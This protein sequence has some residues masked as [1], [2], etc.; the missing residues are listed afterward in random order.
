MAT[1]YECSFSYLGYLFEVITKSQDSSRPKRIVNLRI[2]PDKINKIKQR[3]YKSFLSFKK[4]GNFQ[5]L[6][7]RLRYLSCNKQIRKTVNGNLLAGNAY[8]YCYITEPSCLKVFDG[9]ICSLL[10]QFNLNSVQQ[11][12]IKLISF[13]RAYIS[14]M[15]VKYTKRQIAKIKKVWAYDTEN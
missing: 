14:K 7:N 8:M 9:Y 11:D 5:L 12:K 1:N 10:H 13:Y 3:I 6:L 15:V 2:A 4:D